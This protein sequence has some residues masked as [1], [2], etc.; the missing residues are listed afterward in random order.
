MTP[1]QRLTLELSKT[2]TRL[3][4]LAG[5]ATD[6]LTDEH[7]GELDTLERRYIDA[8]RQHRAAVIAEADHEAAA[9]G[10]FPDGST[11]QDGAEVRALIGRVG[12]PDYLAPAAV[13]IGLSGPAAE[14]NTALELPTA[15]PS[16]GVA[17]PWRVLLPDSGLETRGEPEPVGREV[18]AFTTTGAYAGPVR[19]R[20]IL[21]RLFGA[22][23]MGPLGVRLDAVPS[24]RTEWP[25]ITAGVAPEQKAE[26]MAAP[27]RRDRH[28]FATEDPE[29]E[30]ACT[31][32]YEYTHEMAAQVT[33]LEPALRRDLAAAVRSKMSD[34]ILNGDEA[35]N[36][37]EPDGFLTRLT[38][39]DVPAAVAT[40]AD[41]SAS[42][43]ASVDGLHASTEGEV[44]SVIGV[45]AYRHAAAVFQAGSGGVG[46]RSP[47][48]A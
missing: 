28:L 29:T 11:D 22:D 19:Q 46:N 15:G 18:R 37:Q 43:A 30:T 2:R 27:G 1:K 5:I 8:E 40:Y 21:D 31:G 33:G 3:N 38:A 13:G 44:S 48:T 41:Y 6:D 7:R 14:L 36:A 10:L 17:I 42:H 39:P 20:P 12:L 45:A 9:V 35:T 4:E 32:K 47:E 26:T 34:L 16:G 24:G 23:I 25:L